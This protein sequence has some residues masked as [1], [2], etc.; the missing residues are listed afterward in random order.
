[1]GLPYIDER[2]LVAEAGGDPWAINASLQ[3]GS[4]L[5][6]SNLAAAFH[7]AG[8][9]TAEADNA[10]QQA[11]TR[12]E[13]A[14]NHQDGGHPIN[15]SAEV[16][17][18]VKSLGAQSLQLP[19]IGADLENIA[20]ALADA[21]R[22][23]A[24][25]IAALEAQLKS[26]SDLVVQAVNLLNND[27]SLTA[28]DKD[29]LHAF[30]NT[31]EDDALRD[32]KAALAALQTI[33]NDYSDGLQKSLNSLHAEGYDGAPLHGADADG[34]A[35]PS[36][37][38]QAA[39]ADIRQVTNQAVV[40]QMA[41]VRAA[42]EALNKAAA[43]LYTHGPGSPEGEAASAKLPK[44]KADLAHALEDLGKIPDYNSIDP[45]SINVAP[46]GHFMFTYNVNGQSVQ[47]FGQLKNGTGEFFDQATGTYYTFNGGK[48]TGM[49]TPDPGQ[50]EATSEPLFTAI[51]L[52]VGA[53][54]LKAGGE[55]LVQG[56]KMLFSREMLEGVT[57]DNV[58]PRALAGAEQ[59]F[60]AAERNLTSH[61]PLPGT[62]GEPVPGTRPLEP[63]PVEHT[64]PAD[65]PVEHAPAGP[66]VPVLP[67]SPPPALD[68]PPPLPQDHPLFHG[69]TPVEPGPE[70]THADGRLL[71]PDD[72]LPTKPY[73][74]PGTVVPDA[75]LPA[76][77]VLGR[78]GS[79]FGAYLAP[80]GTPFAQ[81]S[82]PPESALK[83][84]YQYVVEDPNLLPRG[85]HIEQ[86]EVAPWFHQPGGGT[87]YRV[88]GP[89]GKDAPVDAL[90]DS[91]YLGDVRAHD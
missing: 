77:T 56:V 30:I 66:H 44:L 86:S 31:C 51:T 64:P 18:V 32:T 5:Q 2:A 55:A 41:K 81:L 67:D 70:F 90:L 61:G 46:D 73:A 58:F 8:R 33:R 23:G 69:Y 76:G 6:I 88:I 13:A 59:H 43:D 49:R 78:F 17:R 72:S 84:Y 26:I 7:R 54:E 62:S 65:V 60:Q 20:A 82:L 21:Q 89:D 40:D 39:L 52:A 74:V 47:A 3:A 87:Q 79:P 53:P 45:A 36:P 4:P 9:C 38:Q 50:V 48:L 80:D 85:Y 71:Y 14:W 35:P 83:P 15:D 25:R 22:A 19:K 91:G 28:A 68:P 42:Q 24:A 57:A 1:M 27:K 75:N 29:A 12:F 63:P 11:R 16:Q 34:V 37:A 10:F